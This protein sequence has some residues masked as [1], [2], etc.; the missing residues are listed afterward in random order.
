MINGQVAL[1]RLST[2]EIL[3]RFKEHDC[4]VTSI[5]FDGINLVSGAADGKIV[6]YS[7]TYGLDMGAN[8]GAVE[9]KDLEALL[10]APENTTILLQ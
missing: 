3:D 1:I 2:G 4:E 10:S 5:D 9:T 7:L 6:H 8:E